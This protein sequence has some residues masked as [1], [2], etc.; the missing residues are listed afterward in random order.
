MIFTTNSELMRLNF[1]VIKCSLRANI[2]SFGIY[3]VQINKNWSIASQSF[4]FN[5][6]EDN[7]HNICF[8]NILNF[9]TIWLIIACNSELYYNSFGSLFIILATV[10]EKKCKKIG[11]LQI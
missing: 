7:I 11:T 3:Y 6:K 5:I 2:Q 10:S 8:C 4:I 1:S 9:K